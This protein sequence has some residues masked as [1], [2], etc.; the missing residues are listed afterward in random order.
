[1][2][3]SR[4]HHIHRIEHAPSRAYGWR[5]QVQ[6]RNQVIIE[7][8]TDNLYAGQRSALKAALQRR[9]KILNGLQDR[10]YN[11]WRNRKRRNNTSG[12][13]GVGRYVSRER[14]ATSVIERISWQAFW[15]DSDGRRRSRKFS[16]N[17]YGEHGLVSWPVRRDDRHC[18]Y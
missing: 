8:F 11:V 15:D 17:R 12:I 4:Y 6:R 18:A 14:N 16:V 13:V 5:V 3:P 1:M 9:D 10:R 7:L 2:P